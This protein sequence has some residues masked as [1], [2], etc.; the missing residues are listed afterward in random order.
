MNKVE[1]LKD[2]RN[3]SRSN[4]FTVE[5]PTISKAEQKKIEELVQELVDEGRIKLRETLQR[6]YSLSIHGVL[7]Y[8]SE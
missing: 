8:A 3:A 1:L 7:K 5:I 2:M 4:M 6:D